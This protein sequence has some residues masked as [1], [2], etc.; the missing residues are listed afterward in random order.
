MSN[1]DRFTD[2]EKQLLSSTPILIGSAMAFAESSGLATVKEIFASAKTY[3]GGLK[4]YPENEIIQGI[5][6]NLGDREKAMAQAKA[7]R[8]DTIA[9]LKE[10]GVDSPEKIR[11]LLMADTR[12]ITD[13]LAEKA[14]PEE[15]AEYKDWALEVA[16]NVARAA[17]EGGF[18]GFGGERVSAGEKALFAELASV[19]GSDARL[20]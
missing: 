5:L 12:E 15:A 6:H 9:R 20:T 1:F 16:E 8:Q 18:L 14:S 13:I 10:K 7:L 19:L 11:K 3:A 17:K 4:A 2:E